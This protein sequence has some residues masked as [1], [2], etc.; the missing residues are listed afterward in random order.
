ME[1]EK[2]KAALAEARTAYR[3]AWAQL[4]EMNGGVMEK[5]DTCKANKVCDHNKYGFEDC[6]NYIS[7]WISVDDRLPE[8]E[9]NVLCYYGFD[10]G[11]GDLGMMFIGVLCYFCFDSR[12]HWQHEG[13]GLKVTHWMPLPE[14]PTMKGG[15]E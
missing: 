8:N 6:D 9:K 2:E 11:D 14:P 5:C 3:K 13:N 12:P 4:I 7:E 1:K 15:A 10:R